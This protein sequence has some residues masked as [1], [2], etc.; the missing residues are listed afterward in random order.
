[1]GTPLP[2]PTPVEQAWLDENPAPPLS[3]EQARRSGVMLRAGIEQSKAS[4]VPDDVEQA[5]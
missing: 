2:P 5:S 4:G 3:A 1:M